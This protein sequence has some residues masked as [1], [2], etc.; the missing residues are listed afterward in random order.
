M[1]L[2]IPFR[3]IFI[4]HKAGEKWNT[5]HCFI[6]FRKIY[7]IILLRCCGFCVKIPP[8]SRAGKWNCEKC[9]ISSHIM[10]GMHATVLPP[11][12]KASKRFGC[13][14][15]NNPLQ[16]RFRVFHVLNFIMLFEGGRRREN[17]L[18]C[19]LVR[20]LLRGGSRRRGRFA[21]LYVAALN[22]I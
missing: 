4:F 18:S 7:L 12:I 6:S 3:N 10:G 11:S 14:L 21:L 20:T 19:T 17:L 8:P 9:F 5:F 22:R 16:I 15:L 1:I 2:P 13:N